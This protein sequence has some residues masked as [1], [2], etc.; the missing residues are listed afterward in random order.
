[1]H[2]RQAGGAD[3][4]AAGLQPTGG[5]DRDATADRRVAAL[6]RGSAVASRDQPEVLDLLHLT[7][8]GGVVHLGDVDVSGPDPGGLP[9]PLG[10]PWADVLV[11]LHAGPR[12]AV[13]EDAGPDPHRPP[14]SQAV[15]GGGGADERGGG[16]VADR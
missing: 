5:V 1:V 10:R 6:G 13:A 8:G 2:L 3:G 4:V 14:A 16:S 15:R 7:D 11:G 9:Q 12:A